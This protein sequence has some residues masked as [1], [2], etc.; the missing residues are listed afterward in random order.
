MWLRSFHS[1][2]VQAASVWVSEACHGLDR[3]TAAE[4]IAAQQ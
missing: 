2:S 4:R 1:R 3:R